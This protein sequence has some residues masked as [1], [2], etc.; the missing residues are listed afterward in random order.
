MVQQVR[1]RLAGDLD[2]QVGGGRE[3]RQPQ[4]SGPMPLREHHLLIGAVHGA[5]AAHAALQRPPHARRQ[6][7]VTAQQFL[8]DRHRAQLRRAFQQRDDLL[9]EDAGQRVGPAAVTDGLSLVRCLSAASAAHS[10]LRLGAS[11]S[12]RAFSP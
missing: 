6:V 2:R 1:Q 12:T 9:V 10:D 11:R 7:G 3:V 4:V 8:E 5:P